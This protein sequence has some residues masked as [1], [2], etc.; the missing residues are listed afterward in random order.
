MS[1][2][3][4]IV[5]MITWYNPIRKIIVPYMIDSISLFTCINVCAYPHYCGHWTKFYFMDLLL[6]THKILL[7]LYYLIWWI[8][9]HRMPLVLTVFT[10]TITTLNKNIFL[11]YYNIHYNWLKTFSCLILSACKILYILGNPALLLWSISHKI[12]LS[13]IYF[14]NEFLFLYWNYSSSQVWAIH[15]SVL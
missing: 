15:P 4:W 2:L 9:P 12:F 6:F 14:H 13:I 10:W 8:L 7:Y 11:S 1:C 3:I 5:R